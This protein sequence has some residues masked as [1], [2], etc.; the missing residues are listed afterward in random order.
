MKKLCS[1]LLTTAILIC[2]CV[3]PVHGAGAAESAGYG[4]F[5]QEFIRYAYPDYDDI[6]KLDPGFADMIDRNTI[7]NELYHH[8]TDGELDWA[9]VEADTGWHMEMLVRDVV[10][11][12]A[13]AADSI[14]NPFQYRYG[15]YNAET[16]QFYGLE[17][18]KNADKY[19]GLDRQVRGAAHRRA[20]YAY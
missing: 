11:G 14:A 20:H 10:L 3:I 19:P 16:Q 7:Y 18:I 1:I 5:Y 13:F 17:E 4:F 8:Y 9:L 6:V 15:V 2:A 12:R